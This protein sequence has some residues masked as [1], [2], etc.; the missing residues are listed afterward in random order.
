MAEPGMLSPMRNG[1]MG[2]AALITSVCLGARCMAADADVSAGRAVFRE[3]CALC[4]V[5]EPGDGGGGQGPSLVGVFG[6]HA[7]GDP[8]WS[9][10]H[11]LA[12][13]DRTWDAKTLDRF[14]AAPTTVV[15]GTNMVVAVPESRDR[16]ELIAYFQSV[17]HPADAPV[18]Q[19]A[20]AGAGDW[21]LDHPGRAH[22]IE[23]DALPAPFAS[24]S[25]RNPPRMVDPPP[26]ARLAVPPGFRVDVFARDLVGP[27]KMLVA[28]NG[29][30]LVSETSGGRITVLRPAAD[31]G[32][33]ATRS[34]WVAGLKQP[35]GLAFYPDADHPQWLY[36]A[37]T[38]RIVRYQYATGDL[39][40]RGSPE[41]VV[42]SLPAG[43]GH[44]T[45]DIVFSPDGTRFYVSV[46]S[47]SNVAEEMPKESLA[48]AK[49]WDAMHGLGAAWDKETSRADVLVFS[50][51]QPTGAA[52][53]ATGLRNCVGLTRRPGSSDLW[54]TVNERDGLGDDLVPDYSTH[55]EQGSFYGWPWYYL[56]SHEDPRQAG[57]RPDLRGRVT[58]PDVL[59]QAHSAALGL[60]FYVATSGCSAFPA[61][62]VGDAF[63]TFH[64]SWNRGF[65]TGHKL[66]RVRMQQ[67][68]ATGGYED[69][70]TGFIVDDGD[71]W[72]RPVAT[73]ELADGSLLMS[74]DG[75]NL[76]Y[77]ISYGNNCTSRRHGA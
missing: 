25:H 48:D 41:I 61:D 14:L 23:V 24:E 3:R 65:R 52:T 75:E 19:S 43:G 57:E 17:V 37:E 32:S 47:G 73:V 46:G 56:G 4:H 12:A 36:V 13:F 10:T 51:D 22:R 20:P 74:D 15:P 45:R 58:I 71:A 5:A 67:G 18:P 33:V 34:V 66:V 59:Y 26:N 1:W 39:V 76:I 72:G 42:P 9:Y 63:A 54:C 30:I 6:R 70:L 50:T 28:A 16:G 68:R 2:L 40:A 64:G 53:Y 38:N 27:R 21:R 77:R 29:D 11:A 7:A 55:L 31:A 49:Q 35:F 60:E 44:F 8:R 69:F 62:Y